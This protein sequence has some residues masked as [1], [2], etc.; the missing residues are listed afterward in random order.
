MWISRF[1][2][3]LKELKLRKRYN[4]LGVEIA[5]ILLVKILL[6]YLLW[7]MCFSHPVAKDARQSAVTRVILN[8]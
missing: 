6:L 8:H 7:A 2:T 3:H 5:V 4:R 1:T